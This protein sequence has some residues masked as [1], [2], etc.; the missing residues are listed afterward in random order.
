MSRHAGA[1]AAAACA[2]AA[3][4]LAI[5]CGDVPTFPQGITFITPV[6]TPSPS[7]AFGDTLRDSLGRAAPLRVFAIG[8]SGADTIRG[9]TVRYLVTTID[10]TTSART[11]VDPE[12]YLVAGAALGPVRV[13][14]Q[15]T[16]GTASS[17]FR[18]QTSELTLD[19][20]A[21]ADSVARTTS[22]VLLDTLPTAVPLSVTV[23]GVGPAGRATVSGIRV[24]YRIVRTFPALPLAGRY[25]LTDDG[26]NV[27]RP[28][29]T[30]AIDT[31]TASGVASRTLL[32]LEALAGGANADSVL[33][34]ATAASHRN[35]PLRGS[36]V[37][38]VVK[39]RP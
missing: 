9:V 7:V 35:E 14:G 26:S 24:R 17:P 19:V 30:V 15:V 10:T 2:V 28:D 1:G 3:M 36:P 13:V 21:R 22:A 20:V 38:F 16:D 37:R 8:A 4:V 27:L 32:G 6:V 12:G 34:E 39:H 18:L 25:F 29:S 33:V 5:A 11:T 31:T 23:T